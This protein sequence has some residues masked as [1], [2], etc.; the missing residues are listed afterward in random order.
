MGFT[1]SIKGKDTEISLG[2][3]IVS[4]VHVVVATP[5]DSMAKSSS[6]AATMFVGGKLTVNPGETNTDTLNLFKWSLV[7][8]KNAD[9][10]RDVTVEVITN[11][12]IFRTIDFPNAF[13]ID[14]NE[15]YSDSTGM[16]QFSLV[17]RQKVDQ[18]SKI[19]VDAGNKSS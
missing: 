11:D 8:A 2:E 4:T 16:G 1:L 15:R 3:K 17:L 13:V 18:M 14:Y 5:N 6:V 9:A 10:Y 12:Q 7:S 19:K